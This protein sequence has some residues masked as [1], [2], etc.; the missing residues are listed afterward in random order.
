MADRNRQAHGVAARL[1][2]ETGVGLRGDTVAVVE[3]DAGWAGIYARLEEDIRT[4][5]GPDN[6][7]IQHVGSTAV[8]GLAAKPVIDIAVGLAKP[9]D[10]HDVVR[11]LTELGMSYKG[12]LG[13][14]GGLFFTIEPSDGVVA[15]HVHVV[16]INDFQWRWYLRFRDEL[17]NNAE[18]ASEYSRQ[19]SIAAANNAQDRQ[20]YTAAKSEWV[21]STVQKLDTA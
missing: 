3:H 4:A 1:E 14:Y 16:D 9:I 8:P 7:D 5:L 11:R 6:G 19:K 13:I 18:L 17:R 2:G 21:L 10:E 20:A 12:D 15:S